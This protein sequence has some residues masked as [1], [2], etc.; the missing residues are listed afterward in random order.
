VLSV[1]RNQEIVRAATDLS[2]L[3]LGVSR[4]ELL[5]RLVTASP[6]QRVVDDVD[7]SVILVEQRRE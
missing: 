6:A 3:I 4:R 7:W 1:T 2:L 5:G